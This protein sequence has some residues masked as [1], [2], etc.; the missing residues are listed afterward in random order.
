MLKPKKK[1]QKYLTVK[2]QKDGE[3]KVF[4]FKFSSAMQKLKAI[5]KLGGAM[6]DHWELVELSGNSGYVDSMKKL[7]EGYHAGDKIPIKK[8]MSLSGSK[9]LPKRISA[10]LTPEEKDS[11]DKT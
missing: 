2:I 5:K 3:I 4:E 1:D 9:V 6:R 8:M 7:I 11:L 10:L